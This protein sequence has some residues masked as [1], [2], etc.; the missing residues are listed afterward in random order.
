MNLW[1]FENTDLIT[2]LI[3]SVFIISFFAQIY[4]YLIIFSAAARKTITLNNNTK[5]YPPVS[6]IICARDEAENLEKFLP[7]VLEQDYPDFEVVVV[8][9]CSEDDTEIILSAFE[10]KYAHLKVSTIKKDPV[11]SHGKK[12]ALTVGIKAAKNE[13][14]LLTDAD[15]YPNSRLWIKYMMRHFN[16]NTDIVLG[17]GLY[18]KKPGLLNLLIR[19]ETA[20]I[21]MQ[22]ISLARRGSPYM[23]IGRNLAYRKELFFK[24]KGFGP[25]NQLKSGDDDLFINKTAFKQNTATETSRDSFTYSIP[26][27]TWKNWLNQ[28]KR[29]LTT[30]KFYQPSTKRILGFEFLSRFF[31]SLSFILAL[32]KYNFTEY[33]LAIYFLQLITKAVV[34]NKTFKRLN[35]KNLFLPS[36]IIEPLIPFLYG[37]LHF[38]NILERK[39]NKWI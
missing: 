18:E 36:L 13:L 28:K 29:H 33:L 22:Y 27:K 7:L 15:C 4:Y 1:F 34:Y 24:N 2:K 35:E 16:E 31:L 30:G 23:G 3:L 25:H 26:E 37:V 6:V 5:K 8:N 21:A 39:R 19:L 10:K 9:D 12:L 17:I 14:L 38:S 32:F 20:F 11:F